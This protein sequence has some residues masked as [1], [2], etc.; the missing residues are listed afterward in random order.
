MDLHQL[1]GS[2][3]SPKP[4]FPTLPIVTPDPPRL[5]TRE[6]YG[7]L[8][9]LGIAGLA[10]VVALVGWFG[11]GVWSL[12]TVWTNVYILHDES[13]PEA[14]RI[15]AAFALS[16]DPSVNERQ[17]WDICLRKPLPP[18]ARYILAES[19]T[20]EAAS[21]DPSGYATT[22]AKSPDWPGW[23]RVLLA[24]PMAYA[25]TEGIAFPRASLELIAKNPDPFVSLWGKF[26]LANGRPEDSSSRQALESESK[27]GGATREFAGYLLRALERG[28]H[29]AD[30]TRILDE[31]TDWLRNQDPE[32]EKVWTGWTL[33][34]GRLVAKPAPKLH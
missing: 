5:T 31:A 6:K 13:R 29:L 27:S 17:R 33:E 22:I 24:R 20:A 7:S 1:P 4:S 14:E 32:A 8:F 11:L 34:E 25:S 30:Q 3:G 9:Y 12:R 2:N 28:G 26:L 18:L 21:A 19:L 15:Q 23:F 10:V 16:R